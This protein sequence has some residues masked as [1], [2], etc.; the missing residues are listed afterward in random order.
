[1]SEFVEEKEL[2]REM[3]EPVEW[4]AECPVMDEEE[5]VW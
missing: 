2:F 5:I 4:P 1:V 3:S